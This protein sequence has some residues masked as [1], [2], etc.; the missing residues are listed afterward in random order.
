MS[1]CRFLGSAVFFAVKAVLNAVGRFD[2][3]AEKGPTVAS[4]DWG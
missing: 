4:K 1:A 2:E 3:G